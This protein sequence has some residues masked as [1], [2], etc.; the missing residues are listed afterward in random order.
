MIETKPIDDD[1]GRILPFSIP[2]VRQVRVLRKPQYTGVSVWLGDIYHG[3]CGVE[4]LTEIWVEA[5]IVEDIRGMIQDTPHKYESFYLQADT[6]FRIC[7]NNDNNMLPFSRSITE[8]AEFRK[9]LSI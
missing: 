1:D 3:L 2:M 4:N 6:M 8:N 5:S 9:L 7:V